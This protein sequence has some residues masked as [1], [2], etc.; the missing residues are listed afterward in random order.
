MPCMKKVYNDKKA[1]V[2]WSAAKKEERSRSCWLTERFV[3]PSVYMGV[4]W[5]VLLKTRPG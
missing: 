2:H 4:R 1:S 3:P 5:F